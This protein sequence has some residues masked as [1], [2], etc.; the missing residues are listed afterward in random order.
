M[1]KRPG[2]NGQTGQRS[3]SRKEM[4]ASFPSPSYT[5]IIPYRNIQMTGS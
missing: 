5:N 4:G 1:V 2:S 3:R